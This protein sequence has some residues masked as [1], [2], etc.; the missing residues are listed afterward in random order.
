M[1]VELT[2]PAT[3]GGITVTINPVTKGLQLPETI[4]IPEGSVSASAPISTANTSRKS[5][6]T[7]EAIANGRS[8][9]TNLN[10]TFN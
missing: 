2:S 3:A 4:F 6:Y 1:T 7:I 8:I 10:V 5:A 9:S